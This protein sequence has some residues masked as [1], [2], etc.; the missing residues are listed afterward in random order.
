MGSFFNSGACRR[1]SGCPHLYT[2]RFRNIRGK[3]SEESDFPTQDAA[4]ER[5]TALCPA[6]KSTPRSI[7]EQL[8]TLGE[9]TFGEYAKA[10][11][12]RRRGIIALD[13]LLD[14]SPPEYRPSP[15]VTPT[16]EQVGLLR[17]ARDDDDA[18]RLIVDLMAGMG[19][20]NGEA[21][22][23]NVNNMVAKDVYRVHQQVH[24]RTVTLEP[25][26]HRKTGEFREA[27]LPSFVRESIEQHATTHGTF[28]GGSLL[29]TMR[30][31]TGN[32]FLSPTTLRRWWTQLQE[33]KANLVPE[34]MTMYSFRHYFASNALGQGIPITDVADWMGHSDINIT[35]RTYRHLLPG[36]VSKAATLLNNGLNFNTTTMEAPEVAAAA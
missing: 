30:P 16:K 35:F 1:P 36:S 26:K 23:V 21:L 29:K 24:D 6:R 12:A 10:W 8:E 27:P 3:Q 25:L 18:F 14:V 15:T 31:S 2:I 19:L 17:V 13:P 28:A 9:M 11:F 22:A 5:L 33:Q 20:R 32:A 34:G 7:A 4:I